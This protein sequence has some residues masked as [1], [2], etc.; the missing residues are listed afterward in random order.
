[1]DGIGK[2]RQAMIAA[3]TLALATTACGE[4]EDFWDRNLGITG[5]VVLSD[6]GAFLSSSLDELI[7]VRADARRD[8]VLDRYPVSESPEVIQVMDDDRILLWS[9]E[10]KRL[11][12]VD[13]DGATARS[14]DLGTAFGG[15]QVS[16]E[17]RYVVAWVTSSSRDDDF[18]I[19]A[20]QVAIVD[21]NED[22]GADN[23]RL[24]TLDSYGDAPLGVYI[25][26][27]EKAGG[28]IRQ[29]ALV[30]WRSYVTVLDLR[31]PSL[32]AV[33]VP[34]R[35]E[36]SN[37]EIIPGAMKFAEGEEDLVR[38]YFI[39]HSSDDLYEITVAPDLLAD[40]GASAVAINLFPTAP[41]P[42]EF[43]LY[44]LTGGDLP[45]ICASNR[46]VITDPESSETEVLQLAINP[47]SL[48]VFEMAALD[49]ESIEGFAL[50]SSSSYSQFYLVE[51]EHV[52]LK[53]SKA[54]H[55]TAA[56]APVVDVIELPGQGQ[57]LLFHT[58]G[59]SAISVSRPADGTIQS[60]VGTGSME[61][62]LFLS[63]EDLLLVL[64]MRDGARYLVAMDTVSL[65][66]R[67]VELEGSTGQG[68]GLMALPDASQVLVWL[69]GE[70]RLIKAP[71]D[72]KERS[73]LTDYP[74]FLFDGLMD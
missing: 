71:L 35:P 29:T 18:F 27:G 1:M 9:A 11:D 24:I 73:D 59:D 43:Q 40:L 60:I 47:S 55:L 58:A 21:L 54:L 17:G 74:M 2:I 7:V 52:A 16:P 57:F 4:R 48:R 62:R 14:Y 30:A 12:M 49:G 23:P 25:A 8:L 70:Q 42:V 46:L 66:A 50:I 53:K 56:P 10:E 65:H 13:P 61:T 64:T 67:A 3:A 37:D 26:P 39:S 44:R 28:A 63:E 31:D 15:F 72:F 19:L 68:A 20:G 38:A 45:T 51:L 36:D 22:P 32:P 69:A 6:G 33:S 34:L 41:G 5:P